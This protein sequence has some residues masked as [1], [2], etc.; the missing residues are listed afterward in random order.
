MPLS[1]VRPLTAAT[2]ATAATAA[3]VATAAAAATDATTDAITHHHPHD[4]NH[5]TFAL[6]YQVDRNQALLCATIHMIVRSFDEEQVSDGGG[7]GGGGEGKGKG[8]G[9]EHGAA[10]RA[11]SKQIRMSLTPHTPHPRSCRLPIS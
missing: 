3:T 7:G 4:P 9:G 2:V 11:L 1:V 8:K 6:R 5:H 10:N